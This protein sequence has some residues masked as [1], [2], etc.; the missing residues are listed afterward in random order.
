MIAARAAPRPI[1]ALL[2][3]F[4]LCAGVV[5]PCVIHAAYA[6]QAPMAVLTDTVEYCDQLQVRLNA[7]PAHPPDVVKLVKE[8]RQM[9]DHGEIRAGIARLRRAIMI[10]KNLKPCG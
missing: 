1:L 5:A 7:C 2:A 10:Q 3:G 6:Q 8:G 4:G 9:C